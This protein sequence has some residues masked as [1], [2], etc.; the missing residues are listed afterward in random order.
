MARS[1]PSRRFP[2]GPY[3]EPQVSPALRGPKRTGPIGELVPGDD[4]EVAR[5][6]ARLGRKARKDPIVY[7]IKLTGDLVED[8]Q[9]ATASVLQPFWTFT[10]RRDMALLSLVAVELSCTTVSSSG[11]VNMNIKNLTRTAAEGTNIFVIYSANPVVIPVGQYNSETEAQ[12]TYEINW[13]NS[14]VQLG[15]RLGFNFTSIGTGVRGVQVGL[16]FR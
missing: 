3:I 6:L 1:Y 15:D 12:P 9:L 2:G 7:D 5:I 13:E 11:A 14:Q 4:V 8:R 10:I 16:W